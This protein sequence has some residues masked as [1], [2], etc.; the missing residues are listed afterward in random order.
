MTR[1]LIF[2]IVET[3][4]NI[5]FTTLFMA[6]FS[7]NF[8]YQFTKTVKIILKYLKDSREQRIT[9]SRTDKEALKIQDYSDFNW[10]NNKESQQSTSNYIFILNGGL[11]S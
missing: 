2:L 7:K 8:S 9:Y 10:A 3:R 5:T 6:H 4:P 1:S 11:V